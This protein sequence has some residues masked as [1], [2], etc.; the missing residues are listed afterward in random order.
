MVLYV[1]SATVNA[2]LRDPGTNMGSN[3]QCGSVWVAHQHQ[4]PMTTCLALPGAHR[5]EKVLTQGHFLQGSKLRRANSRRTETWS[6]PI[7]RREGQAQ[8]QK[9]G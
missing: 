5:A 2:G 3:S 8:G 6:V 4:G 9:S 7:V 1:K